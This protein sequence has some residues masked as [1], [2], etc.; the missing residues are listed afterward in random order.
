MTPRKLKHDMKIR[1]DGDVW[2]IWGLGVERD[3]K[4]TYAHLASTTRGKHQRNGWVP[5]QV[6]RYI[7]GVKAQ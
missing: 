7:K 3:G 4:E 2:V 1:I 5:M 6:Q